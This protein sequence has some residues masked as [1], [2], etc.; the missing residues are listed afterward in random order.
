MIIFKR[1][2]HFQESSSWICWSFNFLN[3]DNYAIGIS[4]LSSIYWVSFFRNHIESCAG[5]CMPLR[6]PTKKTQIATPRRTLIFANTTSLEQF[7]Y[8]ICSHLESCF[9]EGQGLSRNPSIH[10]KTN[11]Y[12]ADQKKGF[13]IWVQSTRWLI[14]YLQ[15]NMIN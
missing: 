15:R 3:A 8:E 12:W 4:S 1:W 5:G 14:E 9:S 11:W 10:N 6:M 13:L 2:T 7:L